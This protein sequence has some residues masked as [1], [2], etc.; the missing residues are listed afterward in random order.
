MIVLAT[1]AVHLAIPKWANSLALILLTKSML[2]D[3]W[4]F[5]TLAAMNIDS[6]TL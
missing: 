4:N 6:I 3:N 1:L 5:E 2:K